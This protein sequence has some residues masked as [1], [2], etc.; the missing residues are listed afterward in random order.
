M[1]NAN[2]HK[3]IF[4]FRFT[5]LISSAAFRLRSSILDIELQSRKPEVILLVLDEGSDLEPLYKFL[6]AEGLDPKTYSMW[7]SV[8]SSSDHD[9]VTLPQYVLEIVRR[10]KCGVDF[11]FVASLD[12][13]DGKDEPDSHVS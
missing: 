13:D 10:T 2:Y 12:P 4:R 3:E 7:A 8:V 5:K 6:E 11:S 1:E 9:G